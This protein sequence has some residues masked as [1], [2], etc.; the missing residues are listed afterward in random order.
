MPQRC[1]SWLPAFSQEQSIAAS[2]NQYQALQATHK[3]TLS[4]M[5]TTHK[6]A[7]VELEQQLQEARELLTKTQAANRDLET[8]AE[9]LKQE[10]ESAKV[11]ISW[12]RAAQV[13]TLSLCRSRYPNLDLSPKSVELTW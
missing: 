1:S 12:K 11:C 8:Q 9:E 6:A 7:I 4:A 10:V 5:A 13:R 2:Q 3:E